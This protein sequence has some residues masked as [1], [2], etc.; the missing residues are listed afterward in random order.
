LPACSHILNDRGNQPVG[1][2]FKFQIVHRR[3]SN[4]RIRRNDFNAP[5]VISSETRLPLARRPLGR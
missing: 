2:L 1:I 3:T 5:I 4:P